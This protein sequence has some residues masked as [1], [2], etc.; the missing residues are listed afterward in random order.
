ME[1][2][3]LHII[4]FHGMPCA[5]KDTQADKLL[6]QSEKPVKISTGEIFRDAIKQTGQYAKYYSYIEE[7][8]ETVFNGG[9]I[10]DKNI[11]EVVRLEIKQVI[12]EGKRTIIF[13][14]FP[15]T[16]EQSSRFDK[17]V[18]RLSNEYHIDEKNVYLKIDGGTAIK[19]S[20]KRADDAEKFG[21]DIR[22]EDDPKKFGKRIVEF[23]EKTL[24]MIEKL[25]EKGR[26]I[27]I[28]GT[29]EIKNV[30][31]EI[32]VHLEGFKPGK[33]RLY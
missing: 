27:T 22:K 5:G 16:S 15:R 33:E 10:Q 17:I 26:L 31:Q 23:K 18:S 13:T 24:L 4:Y 25:K 28:D 1:K 20:V 6:N 8:K 3:K 11:I 19:R 9:L 12:N 14:G 2:Q 29:Q 21:S 32:N 30:A 7:D